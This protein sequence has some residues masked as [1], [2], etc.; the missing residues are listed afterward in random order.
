[1]RQVRDF[2]G[3]EQLIVDTNIVNQAGEE[4]PLPEYLVGTEV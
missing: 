1:M 4:S 2:F 3:A